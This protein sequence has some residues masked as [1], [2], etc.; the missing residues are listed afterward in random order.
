MNNSTDYKYMIQDMNRIYFGANYTYAEMLEE[1]EIPMKFK[2]AIHRIF[3]K[4]IPLTATLAEQ[5]SLVE[6]T[7]MSYLAY[8][9]LKIKIKVTSLH[10]TEKGYESK[11]LT[12]DE[13]MEEEQSKVRA[14]ESFVEEIMIKKLHLMAFSL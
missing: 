8:H 2:T 5:L 14:E 4:D 13:F 1:D 10:P 6:E 11:Y 12:F 9:Q 7:Q 3:A